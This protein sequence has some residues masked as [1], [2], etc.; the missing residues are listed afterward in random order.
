MSHRVCPWWLG[1]LLVSPLRRW[2]QN[3]RELIIPYVKPGM[4][5]FEP[6][7]GMGFFTIEIA[8][9][10][11]PSG[12]VI[13]VDVQP[14]MTAGLKRRVAKAGLSE[15][16]DARTVT[17]ESL[18]VTDLEGKADFILAFA[19]VHEMPSSSQFFMQ[20]AQ[21]AKTGAQLLLVEPSGHVKPEDFDKELADAAKAGFSCVQ[22][23]VIRRCHAA[24]LRRQ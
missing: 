11:G 9:L 5:V 2:L 6:G 4:T 18:A 13:A 14:R 17:T 12:R 16:V 21:V 22:R 3:P 8:R 15:R 20:A 23:P 19:V 1:Y 10:V 7:P 24:L